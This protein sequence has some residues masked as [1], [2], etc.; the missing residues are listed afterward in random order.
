[1]I[2]KQNIGKRMPHVDAL[3][4]AHHILENNTFEFNLSMCQANDEKIRELK[5]RLEKD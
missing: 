5:T 4:L 1:M 3:S 2:I